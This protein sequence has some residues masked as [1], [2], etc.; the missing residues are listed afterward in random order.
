[1]Y[2][3][4]TTRRLCI[5]VAGISTPLS[6]R[7]L[8]HRIQCRNSMD[9]SFNI[10]G[11]I[12]LFGLTTGQRPSVS[13]TFADTS[14]MKYERS[15]IIGNNQRQL[16]GEYELADCL[17]ACIDDVT[18]LPC[19]SAEY[20]P[21]D[22]Q[23][24]LSSV[25]NSDETPVGVC[26]SVDYYERYQEI[27]VRVCTTSANC[28]VENAEC[29]DDNLCVCED[30]YYLRGYECIPILGNFPCT[31]DQGDCAA[32]E[33]AR[34]FDH[35]SNPNT[36]N[37]CAC[38]QGYYQFDE[39]NCRQVLDNKPCTS[40][41]QNCTYDIANM[42]CGDHDDDEST[43]DRCTCKSGY[44]TE[45]AACE[46][47]LDNMKC[48]ESSDCDEVEDA[49]CEDEICK[50]ESGYYTTGDT[51]SMVLENFVCTRGQGD[52][53]AI[54]NAECLDHDSN[55]DTDTRCACQ[56]GYYQVEEDCKQVLDNK[57]CTDAAQNCSYDIANIVCDDHD[58]DDSTVF[59]C[60]CKTGYFTAEAACRQ[61]LDNMACSESNDC[62]E[63]LKA[64]CEDDVCRCQTGYF[65]SGDRC[66]RVLGNLACTD[67]SNCSSVEYS[68][69]TGTAGSEKCGCAAKYTMKLDVCEEVLGNSCFS[70]IA[71]VDVIHSSCVQKEGSSFTTCEC[72]AGYYGRGADCIEVLENKE[73]DDVSDCQ[74]IRHA[75]CGD[76]NGKDVCKC[77]DGYLKED[78]IRCDKDI[79]NSKVIIVGAG[80]A[81][82]TA[83]Y[84]LNKAGI[85]NFVIL[86]AADKVGGSLRPEE[87]GGISVNVADELLQ[88][89]DGLLQL[90]S[91]LERLNITT[92]SVESEDYI[93][94]DNPRSNMT[95]ILDETYET[96]YYPVAD[97]VDEL[98]E[99]KNEN[100][101]PDMT[102]RNALSMFGWRPTA[103]DV[104]KNAIEFWEYD[105][106]FNTPP[107]TMS[108]K[109]T[110]ELFE[111]LE[112]DYRIPNSGGALQILEKLINE[113][114][115]DEF[116]ARI[117]TGQYVDEVEYG[118]SGV[119][120]K[121]AANKT[122]KADYVLLTVCSHLLAQDIIEME[123]PRWKK[124]A[125]YAVQQT[126][127][128]KI[129]MKFEHK[130]WDDNA[131][132][133]YPSEV[134]G[135]YTIWQ[136]LEALG[137]VPERS[138][139][140][141]VTLVGDQAVRVSTLH[142]DVVRR[143]ATA[144]LRLMYG[145]DA[146]PNPTDFLFV[147]KESGPTEGSANP[148]FPFGY[149]NDAKMA[150]LANIEQVFFAGSGFS[151]TD[152]GTIPAKYTSGK[153]EALRIKKCLEGECEEKHVPKYM[154]RGCTYSFA[155]NYNEA[156]LED[157]GTCTSKKCPEIPTSGVESVLTSS[158]A[159]LVM[160]LCFWRGAFQ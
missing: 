118:S 30:K 3:N 119:E 43:M 62:N 5:E 112:T 34:C 113:F 83:A 155:Q 36:D 86:E 159:T 47:M 74:G 11:I 38:V 54:E 28:T 96:L 14:W 160:S 71:C 24:I 51:C 6:G 103:T 85:T 108:L 80:L 143:E 68:I 124:E 8:S 44:Y 106:T 97:E 53:N 121:T 7:L 110:V 89:S 140:L 126:Y 139:I 98:G 146:V 125:I 132:I 149:S 123:L 22:K 69:C 70:D 145:D 144:V 57:P 25:I 91:E 27:G 78:S 59:T 58:E 148:T 92:A 35:D 116:D 128:A 101:E 147:R 142:A 151:L 102:S 12:C 50:C 48:S 20:A 136:D 90:L 157:D 67:S 17:Q 88:A 138:N 15:C 55:P 66:L 111:N 18:N 73:C 158:L 156:A 52:C 21:A 114:R 42:V 100:D 33:N 131:Y 109:K 94:R 117:V 115:E 82:V 31:L 105:W 4:R 107:E 76:H 135:Y 2:S 154:A 127:R 13:Y 104:L 41:S 133:L 122:Y 81:G 77:E 153:R 9:I 23:C 87:L 84:E 72:D 1:A 19:R 130:F 10:L 129:F 141:L 64:E 56:Q 95:G 150:Y 75:E 32:V 93:V 39:E 60:T 61:M 134:K 49:E 29:G 79:Y 99:D 137:V 152:Y 45:D 65:T 46:Q 16:S 37:T 120:V 26:N 63:L 40:V